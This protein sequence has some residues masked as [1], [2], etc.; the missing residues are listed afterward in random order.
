MK[1][2]DLLAAV[3]GLGAVVLPVVGMGIAMSSETSTGQ[4]V[5]I[6]LA[7]GSMG[8][9]VV[10]FGWYACERRRRQRRMR[11]GRCLKCGYPRPRTSDDPKCPECGW[12]WDSGNPPRWRKQD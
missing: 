3:S 11:E 10:G 6:V 4:T 1:G 5:G 9:A 7:L 12:T 8:A 2:E